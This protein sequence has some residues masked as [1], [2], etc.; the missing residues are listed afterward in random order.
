MEAFCIIVMFIMMMIWLTDIGVN[1]SADQKNGNLNIQPCQTY[2]GSDFEYYTDNDTIPALRTGPVLCAC[3]NT[4]YINVT[5]FQEGDIISI[6]TTLF[7][8]VQSGCVLTTCNVSAGDVLS[9]ACNMDNIFVSGYPGHINITSIVL[10]S[11]LICAVLIIRISAF[12]VSKFLQIVEN[13][14]GLALI[15]GFIVQ[16]AAISTIAARG[17]ISNDFGEGYTTLLEILIIM[18]S[19]IEVI[20]MIWAFIGGRMYPNVAYNK[21]K[22]NDE[23]A[24]AIEVGLATS[25][26]GAVLALLTPRVSERHG[27]ESCIWRLD[28]TES[29]D[30]AA[31]ADVDA[32][33]TAITSVVLAVVL[34]TTL[35]A[36]LTRYAVVADAYTPTYAGIDAKT[37]EEQTGIEL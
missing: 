28:I 26:T 34:V 13:K 20:L 7:S 19:T 14:N 2:N 29:Q 10:A 30:F 11:I 22:V 25:V 37:D 16:A 4:F 9:T 35:T 24:V 27:T 36:T 12:T 17:V 32:N 31:N 6:D 18:M 5:Q 23:R 15:L 1:G 21:L 3:D 8:P 33:I